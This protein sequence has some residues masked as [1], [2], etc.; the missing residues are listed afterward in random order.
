MNVLEVESESTVHVHEVSLEYLGAVA[1]DEAFNE[2][3]VLSKN[4]VFG[5][6]IQCINCHLNRSILPYS[7]S[8][9]KLCANIK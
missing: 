7:P 8:C 3:Y 9:V 5:K 2:A 4:E 1:S 6:L